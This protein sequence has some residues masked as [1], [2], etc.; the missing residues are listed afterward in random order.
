MKMFLFGNIYL[1][2]ENS[3]YKVLDAFNELEQDFFNFSNSFK[4]ILLVGDF[5]SRTSNDLDFT[6]ISK[7]H[8]DNL[9]SMISDFS[10]C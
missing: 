1:P 5:N 7:S 10:N 3:R 9:D 6:H 4:Y 8:Y 2:P